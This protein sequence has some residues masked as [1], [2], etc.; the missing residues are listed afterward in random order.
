[1]HD[2]DDKPEEGTDA[3]THT[4][5]GQPAGEGAKP[6]EPQ[7]DNPVQIGV[8]LKELLESMTMQLESMAKQAAQVDAIGIRLDGLTHAIGEGLAT[9]MGSDDDTKDEPDEDEERDVSDTEAL[10]LSISDIIQD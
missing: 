7:Q 10:D 6:E 4:D 2:E 9:G 1:M 3:N 8:V 5:D